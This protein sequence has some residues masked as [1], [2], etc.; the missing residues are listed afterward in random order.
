[1]A[2]KISTLVDEISLNKLQGKF[3]KVEDYTGYSRMHTLRIFEKWLGTS[4]S[5]ALAF[6]RFEHSLQQIHHSS[7]NLTQI[8]LNCGFYD[9]SHFIRVFKQ[10]A[11]M[12]PR[13]Y[14]LQK[15]EMVGQFAPA[16]A[17]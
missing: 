5:E 12:T 1:M 3:K 15:S 10:F 14:L 2:M 8:A 6:R 17:I 11:Q 4:P 16:S 7:D 13:Q 9:Q